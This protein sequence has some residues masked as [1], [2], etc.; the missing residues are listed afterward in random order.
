MICMHGDGHVK[1]YTA[2]RFRDG[3]MAE[4]TVSTV[5]NENRYFCP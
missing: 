1:W 5:Y 2:N 3:D 4:Y